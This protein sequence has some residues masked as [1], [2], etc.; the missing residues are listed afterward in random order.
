MKIF[1]HSFAKVNTFAVAFFSLITF[2]IAAQCATPAYT[3]CSNLPSGAIQISPNSSFGMN[4]G[5]Y[6]YSGGATTL[7]ISYYN[8][9]TLIICGGPVSINGFN[10]GGDVIITSGSSLI[11]N[12]S[13]NL[14]NNRKIFNM[15]NLTINGTIHVNSDGIINNGVIAV[16]GEMRFNSG[17]RMC[18]GT[19]AA[20]NAG[21]VYNDQ[22]NSITVPSGNACISYSNSFGGNN[23][24]T[25][26]SNLYLCQGNTAS[27]PANS[28]KGNATLISN[29]TSCAVPLS[30]NLISFELE[31]NL[32]NINLKWV[33]ADERSIS[34]FRIEHAGNDGIFKTV[35]TVEAAGTANEERTYS[36]IDENKEPGYHYYRLSEV[37]F[38][39]KVTVLEIKGIELKAEH[40]FSVFP[41][42]TQSGQSTTVLYTASESGNVYVEFFTPVGTLVQRLQLDT[43]TSN[44]SVNLPKGQYLVKLTE[45]ETL[46]ETRSLIVF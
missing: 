39:G 41:N 17:G 9:G 44:H 36:F 22:S 4:S 23:S 15:G 10:P 28:S 25:N 29:C 5:I 43:T 14:Q 12:G 42:P 30:L 19:G 45:N 46:I 37:D 8:G 3:S 26:N 20:L 1:F 35:T 24:V 32:R 2:K 34:H 38:S 11:I 18:M 33:T 31:T 40:L 27:N 7:S 6:Y 16:S 13:V 21:S